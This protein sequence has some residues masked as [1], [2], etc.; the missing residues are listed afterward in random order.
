MN[1]KKELTTQSGETLTYTR[2]LYPGDI[3]LVEKHPLMH[4]SEY[5]KQLHVDLTD[6][7]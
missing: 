2:R 1:G 6:Q 7:N 5:A 3:Y 4:T